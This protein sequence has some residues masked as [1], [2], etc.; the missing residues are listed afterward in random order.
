[1]LARPTPATAKPSKLHIRAFDKLNPIA[2][3]WAYPKAVSATAGTV[4]KPKLIMKREP[5]AGGR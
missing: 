3:I 2:A 4:G 5:V 1:M